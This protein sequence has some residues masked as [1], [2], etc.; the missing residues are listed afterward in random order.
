MIIYKS[1]EIAMRRPDKYN[2]YYERKSYD[3]YYH[4]E[5]KKKVKKN[6]FY[7]LVAIAMLLFIIS[8]LLSI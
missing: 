8:I 7:S 6:L 4:N 2:N 1:N 5:A 3:V